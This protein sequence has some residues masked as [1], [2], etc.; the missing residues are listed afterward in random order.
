MGTVVNFPKKQI[1]IKAS[2]EKTPEG[3]LEDL[4][5][6]WGEHWEKN[7]LNEFIFASAVPYGDA[8]ADYL[9]N[10]N[11][12]SKLEELVGI[13]PSIYRVSDLNFAGW[14]ASF[15]WDGVE[16]TTPRFYT[17]AEA[18]AFNV[19]LYLKLKRDIPKV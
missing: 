14:V 19:L 17:E 12:I 15:Y 10:L 16:M 13:K 1:D 4:T 2:T 5:L 11:A 18:R 9:S 3:I 7:S 6:F 8:E